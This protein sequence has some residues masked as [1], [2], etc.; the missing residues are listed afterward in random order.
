MLTLLSLMMCG[1]RYD[2]FLDTYHHNKNFLNQP[3]V[4]ATDYQDIE[5]SPYLNN[6][7]IDGVIYFKDTSGIKLPLRYNIY[8]NE[9]EYQLKGV[10][11][12]VGNPQSLNKILLGESVFLYLPFI[13][14]GGYFELLE[15]GKC[16]LVQK[17]TVRFKPA[18][19]PKPIEGTISR[20]KFTRE[21]DIF[22]IIVN[23]SKTIEITTM[24]SVINALQDQKLNIESFIKKEEIKNAK[25]ENLIK[26]AEYY[27]SL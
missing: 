20:A 9:M 19:G 27:N 8:A 2:P 13:Q 16:F 24:K 17:R 6:D 5:G 26:I 3:A 12:L 15:S 10:S 1:Q 25:K 21:P 18:E 11:Y 14:N 4:N 22:F 7:F 23:D